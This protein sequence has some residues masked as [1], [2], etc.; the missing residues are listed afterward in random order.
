MDIT[1]SKATT[2]L[3][4]VSD[5]P[6]KIIEHF[7]K[8]ITVNYIYNDIKDIYIT[9][10]KPYWFKYYIAI[11]H[12]IYI[13]IKTKTFT[14][15]YISITVYKNDNIKKHDIMT[16]DGLKSYVNYNNTIDFNDIIYEF[17]DNTTRSFINEKLVEKIINDIEVLTEPDSYETEY[18]LK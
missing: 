13:L 12:N 17:Y 2:N 16:V 11:K 5:I 8:F 1:S 6:H 7:E 18:V 3:I 9:E 10:N 14:D 15:T 4:Q